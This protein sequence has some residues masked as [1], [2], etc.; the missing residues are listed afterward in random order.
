MFSLKI[1]ARLKLGFSATLPCVHLLNYDVIVRDDVRSIRGNIMTDGCG[2]IGVRRLAFIS[3]RLILFHE[4]AD[5]A[6]RTPFHIS[7]GSAQCDRASNPS[8]PLPAIVQFRMISFMGLYKGCLTTCKD[9]SLCPAGCIVVRPSMKKAGGPLHLTESDHCTLFIN[10]TFES[11]EI[12]MIDGVLK[13]KKATDSI[14]DS[15][16]LLNRYSL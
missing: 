8:L 3:I 9:E 16:A 1:N 7:N 10:C 2:L 12:D 5:L 4:Q 6:R 15:Y 11:S 13:T 14:L